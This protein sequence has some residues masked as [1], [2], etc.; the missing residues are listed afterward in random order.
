MISWTAP[1]HR[2]RQM[3]RVEIGP[4]F[5]QHLRNLKRQVLPA[6]MISLLGRMENRSNLNFLSKSER[7]EKIALAFSRSLERLGIEM[8]IRTVDDAQYQQ[9]A[10]DYDYDMIIWSYSAS[11]SPGIEQIWRW[12]SNAATIPGTFNMAGVQDPAL[13]AAIEH[14]VK[15][16]SRDDFVTAVR[17]Y[18]RLLMAG[19]YLVPLFHIKEQWVARWKYIERPEN[20]SLYGYQYET[21][22]DNRAK[23]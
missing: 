20:T 9:R 19:H 12:G 5:D 22:W 10:Q 21:W 18:D 23:N 4:F 16:R 7:E 1:T 6:K 3:E 14:I 2:Q 8:T 15:S 17:A 11:L 13:D